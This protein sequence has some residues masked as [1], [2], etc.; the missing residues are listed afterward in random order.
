MG[1]ERH[2][3]AF[4]DAVGRPRRNPRREPCA[5]VSKHL[6]ALVEPCQWDVRVANMTAHVHVQPVEAAVVIEAL[7][8][9]AV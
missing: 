4:G 3:I 5:E 2:D 6:L 9:E 7:R 8:S 1:S